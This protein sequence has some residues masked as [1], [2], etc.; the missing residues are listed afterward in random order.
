VAKK[1]RGLL[2]LIFGPMYSGK[3]DSLIAEVPRYEHADMK[4]V[5]VMSVNNTREDSI[6]THDGDTLPAVK[7]G[8][9]SDLEKTVDL[10]DVEAIF[11][12][13]AFMFTDVEDTVNTIKGWLDRGIDVIVASLDKMGNGSTPRTVVGLL[14]L[15]PDVVEYKIA[16][17]TVRRSLSCNRKKAEYTMIF[18]LDENPVPRDELVDVLPQE[19]EGVEPPERVYKAACWACYYG[20]DIDN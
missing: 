4:Y 13:E 10:A 17:C 2:K 14:A 15:D 12:D 16:A 20:V 7:V 1:A 19:R 18:D 8:L 6:K 3:S 11:I 9:L 5:A